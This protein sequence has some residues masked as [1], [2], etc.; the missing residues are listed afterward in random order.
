MMKIRLVVAR[1][2]VSWVLLDN[3]FHNLNDHLLF[4][5]VKGTVRNVAEGQNICHISSYFSLIKSLYSNQT[6]INIK[7]NCKIL[8]RKHGNPSWKKKF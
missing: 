5:E 7:R 3:M 2:K 1:Q 6:G 4:T 8:Q